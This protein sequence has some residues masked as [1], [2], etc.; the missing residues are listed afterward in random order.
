MAAANNNRPLLEPRPVH[1]G[2]RVPMRQP[3]ILQPT[4]ARPRIMPI[5]IYRDGVN[6]ETWKVLWQ[7]YINNGNYAEANEI[8]EN[9]IREF[10]ENQWLHVINNPISRGGRRY[11]LRSTR[12]RRKH[13]SSR[14]R[15][16]RR[17]SQKRKTRRKRNTRRR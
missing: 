17:K 10:G 5:G 11:K 7:I 13:K 8:Q 12:R 3:L 6:I 16:P 15:K 2:P 1:I 9:A 14:R 4:G